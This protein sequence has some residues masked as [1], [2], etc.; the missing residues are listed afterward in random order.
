MAAGF[1]LGVLSALAGDL[2]VHAVRGG[3]PVPIVRG[4]NLAANVVALLESCTVN[5]TES[6]PD[7]A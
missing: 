6:M 5:A 3:Q 1:A 7:Q 4:E 2:Q